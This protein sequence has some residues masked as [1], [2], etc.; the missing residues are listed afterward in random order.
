MAGFEPAQT[1]WK[2]AMLAVTSHP[3][4]H[5]AFVVRPLTIVTLYTSL[6]PIV[7]NVLYIFVFIEV[8]AQRFDRGGM[9]R[10]GSGEGIPPWA[11]KAGINTR[12]QR[13]GHQPAV[14]PRR[15]RTPVPRKHKKGAGP[16]RPAPLLPQ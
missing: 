15:I 8:S 9:R 6:R 7:Y 2:A 5:R 14:V 3:H 13:C 11:R 4:R 1:T 12:R 16:E 10:V